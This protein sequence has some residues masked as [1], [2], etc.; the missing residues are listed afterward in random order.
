[1]R[2]MYDK[3]DPSYQATIGIDFLSKVS[4]ITAILSRNL[5]SRSPARAGTSSFPSFFNQVNGNLPIILSYRLCTWK[6]AL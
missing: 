2:F 6:I 5:P 3:F 4:E 1:M